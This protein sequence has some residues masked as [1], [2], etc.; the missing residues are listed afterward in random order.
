MV[1][2]VHTLLYARDAEKA[3][4]FLRDILDLPCVDAGRGWLIF[5]LPPAEIAV[6]PDEEAPGRCELYLMCDDVHKTVAEL[7]A[8]GVE[9]TSPVADRGWGLVTM[10]AVP[11]FGAMG[12]YQ[13]KHPVPR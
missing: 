7:R 5:A 4:A 2:A 12:L 1:N 3:R 9:F 6:H 13:P 10:L 8:K 11:G